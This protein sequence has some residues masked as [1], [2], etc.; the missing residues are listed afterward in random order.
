MTSFPSLSDET[1]VAL[2]LATPVAHQWVNVGDVVLHVALAGPEDG[3]P[4]ILLHGFPEAWF[5]WRHQIDALV[6]AGFRLAI[7]DQRGYNLSE[8]PK[9]VRD[10]ALPA[11]ARDV[12]G[13]AA[14]LGWDRYAVVGHD[15]GSA[16]VWQLVQHPPAGLVAASVINVPELVVMRR[17]VFTTRQL[18]RSLYILFFQLPWLPEWTLL[19]NQGRILANRMVSSSRPGTFSDAELAHYRRSWAHP[20]AIRSPLAWYRSAGRRPPPRPETRQVS[21]PMLILWGEQ[22]QFLGKEMVGPSAACVDDVEVIR[23]PS[24]TH[25]VQHEEPAAVNAALIRFLTDK[26]AVGP[27]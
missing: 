27:P 5:G 20:G 14:A 22:D 25:W 13:L 12:E 6:D 15:W 18:F 17:H 9:R 26:L 24:A 4:V 23:F 19:K 21:L 11:L 1:P 7:P 10:Y 2:G 16:V 3:L 8:K